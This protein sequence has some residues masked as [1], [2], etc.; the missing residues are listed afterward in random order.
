MA[1]RKQLDDGRPCEHIGIIMIIIIYDD[2]RHIDNAQ[3]RWELQ[4]VSQLL[5][6]LAERSAR[7]LDILLPLL[8]APVRE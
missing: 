3:V 5:I 7:F 4:P 1:N 8:W 6:I 2:V